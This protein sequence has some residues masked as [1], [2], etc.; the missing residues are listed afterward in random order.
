MSKLFRIFGHGDGRRSKKAIDYVLK[1]SRRDVVAVDPVA[2][3]HK[4]YLKELGEFEHP[5]R[6]KAKASFS[7]EAL[8]DEPPNSIHHHYAHFAVSAMGYR[9]R[10]R[11]FDQVFRT[12]VPRG[13]LHIIESAFVINEFAKELKERGFQVSVVRLSPAELAK[14]ESENSGQFAEENL[15]MRGQ[16]R[17]AIAKGKLQL[18][19]DTTTQLFHGFNDGVNDAEA[20]ASA[21]RVAEDVK[22]VASEKP[23]VK[24]IAKK[25][26]VRYVSS[27]GARS[28]SISMKKAS[29]AK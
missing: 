20:L 2:R 21:R 25:P 22:E 27:K 6:F 15:I 9:G 28:T 11:F 14:L 18:L 10:H 29:E 7:A 24:I 13:R 3:G 26:A 5:K 16:I 1:R 12:L 23:F 17:E 8:A 19:K 4:S